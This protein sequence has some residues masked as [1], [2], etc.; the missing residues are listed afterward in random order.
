MQMLG[1]FE[2]KNPG[3]RCDWEARWHVNASMKGRS[4]WMNVP[5]FEQLWA[6]CARA[7]VS[8]PELH[9]RLKTYLFVEAEKL[10]VAYPTVQH[11]VDV[12]VVGLQ[13]K[14]TLN[15][16]KHCSWLYTQMIP[17]HRFQ[18]SACF[19]LCYFLKNRTCSVHSNT[20]FHYAVGGIFKYFSEPSSW[21][22]YYSLFSLQNPLQAG[23]RRP[24]TRW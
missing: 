3:I 18:T 4:W 1:Q 17:E 19:C 15:N 7:C 21:R 22:R 10:T 9:R 14:V 5:A 20:T 8:A 13:E 11:A 2:D 16:A 6:P 24:N 12:D 23:W